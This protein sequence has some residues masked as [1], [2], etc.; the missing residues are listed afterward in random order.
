MPG[1]IFH[2][3]SLDSDT[4]LAGGSTAHRSF[5]TF[6]PMPEAAV[7]KNHGLI[8]FQNDVGPDAEC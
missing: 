8:L 7:N 5:S 4:W 2:L 1:L 3:M 6:M